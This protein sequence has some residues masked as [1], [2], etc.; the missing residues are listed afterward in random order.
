MS[1]N[2]E[3]N[4]DLSSSNPPQI[5]NPTPHAAIPRPPRV[6]SAPR[7]AAVDT[8][9]KT[10]SPANA[11]T[12]VNKRK[13]KKLKRYLCPVSGCGK[14]FSDRRVLPGHIKTHEPQPELPCPI[15]KRIY[16]RKNSFDEHVVKC[17]VQTEERGVKKYTTNASSMKCAACPNASFSSR[18]EVWEHFK[19]KHIN[20]PKKHVEEKS[21]T[22]C[23][24]RMEGSIR[25]HSRKHFNKSKRECLECKETFVST[26]HFVRH[27]SKEHVVTLRNSDS[28][29]TDEPG[30]SYSCLLCNHSK[31]KLI[32]LHNHVLSA[33]STGFEFCCN[34][35]DY[36]CTSA[37]AMKRHSSIVHFPAFKPLVKCD[38]CQGE[39]S[40]SSQYIH[41]T[42]CS[43]IKKA[44]KE[45]FSVTNQKMQDLQC[46][47]C[48]HKSSHLSG[49]VS[50]GSRAHWN[51]EKC[52]ENGA[53]SD[54]E[55]KGK[56]SQCVDIPALQH[57][58]FLLHFARHHCESQSLEDSAKAR[59]RRRN[60]NK[61]YASIFKQRGKQIQCDKCSKKFYGNYRLQ[62]HMH[63]HSDVRLFHCAP[64][65]KS[66]KT[67]ESLWTHKNW[68]HRVCQY[69]CETCGDSFKTKHHLERH[70]VRHSNVMPY[71]CPV[72]AKKFKR[73]NTLNSHV[74]TH[75]GKQFKCDVCQKD[76]MYSW[77]MRKH[78]R[79]EHH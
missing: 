13:H 35:C 54:S 56:C 7:K 28:Q 55:L 29:S 51:V 36:K 16:Y 52:S 61:R 11:E 33:H 76:F 1:H 75:R 37:P 32:S 45:T 60:G 46:R 65:S 38:F 3:V 62:S 34:Q 77:A 47:I 22:L 26:R 79:E 57:T 17:K 71:E 68:V 5:P 27:F 39:F 74:I 6:E 25:E 49:L 10:S 63:V 9:T 44:T 18:K 12:Q 21:C 58:Q 14:S 8:V 40:S 19:A 48:G 43:G 42:K 23:E 64:C 30:L 15:C 4:T 2:R 59:E 31:Q 50:H 24:G 70:Q 66:F 20:I 41:I 53:S 72:C 73:A 69:T 78:K 67:K